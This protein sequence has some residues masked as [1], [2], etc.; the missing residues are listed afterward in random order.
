[1]DGRREWYTEDTEEHGRKE[2]EDGGKDLPQR[3]AAE[4]TEATESEF[5]K[6]VG[7]ENEREKRR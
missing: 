6:E 5:E 4:Q 7:F 1:M 2:E 3:V